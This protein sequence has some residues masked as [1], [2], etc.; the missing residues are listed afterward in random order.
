MA[1]IDVSFIIPVYNRP[2]EINELL[3]SFN[4]LDGNYDFEIVI[5]ED[6]SDNCSDKIIS[7]YSN[8]LNISYYT[9]RILVQVIQEILV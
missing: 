2:N 9:K 8:D 4:K 1:I 7:N 3:H 5:I 6:G